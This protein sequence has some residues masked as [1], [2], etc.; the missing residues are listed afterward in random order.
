MRSRPLLLWALAGVL[1][2]AMP[3]PAATGP[4]V[5]VTT[6][7]TSG[8]VST[9]VSEGQAAAETPTSGTGAISGVVTDGVTGL[10]LE[11]AVVQLSGGGGVAVVPVSGG[12]VAAPRPGQI[13]DARGRF[14]FTHLPA[15][16]DYALS[17]SRAGYMPGGYKRVPG[18]LSVTR[19]A[20]RD[21]EWV[22]NA[23]VKLW[24][25]AS[26][27]GT[28]RDEL[29]EPVVGVPVRALVTVQV[30]G[31]GQRAAGPTTETDDRG[32]YRLAGLQPGTY[33]IQA[34]SV[35][36]T[37]PAVAAPARPGP[38]SA[39]PPSGRG[40]ATAALPDVPALVRVD[41]SLGRMVGHFATPPPDSGGKVYAM[42]FHPSARSV[43]EATPVS[44]GYGDQR[45]NVDVQLTLVPAVSVSGRVAGP[46]QSLAKMPIRLVPV[47]S[48]SLSVGADAAFTQ[49]DEEGSFT[50]LQVP[51]G[52]YTLIASRTMAEYGVGASS[53][54]DRVM[55]TSVLLITSMSAGQV[56]GSTGVSYVVRSTAGDAVSGRLSVSVGAADLEGLVVPL[57]T[58]V[59]VS[60]HFLWDGSETPPES[61]RLQPPVRLEPADGDLSLG[62]RN[63]MNVR[64]DGQALPSPLPFEL[65]GVL[66]GRY[67]LSY[68]ESGGF[69]LEGAEWNGRDLLAMPLEVDG[70]KDV[71]GV[72]IR[73]SSKRIALTGSVQDANGAPATTGAVLTFPASPALW[74]N[75]GLSANLFRTSTIVSDGTF[76]VDR[77][78]PGEYLIVAV[79]DEDRSKWLD[80]EFLAGVAG[81][82]TR[83]RVEPGATISRNLRMVGGRE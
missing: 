12:G 31:R 13:T 83:I 56:P 33:V 25:P 58:G 34:P 78:V 68:V 72:V 30:A 26:I 81:F 22:T 43:A 10:P 49:T 82:A 5:V 74:R 53:S 64:P 77:L 24:R 66:P 45:E 21:G 48:E 75:F 36:I 15:F 63:R 73:L 46:A 59:K 80:A 11:G 16:P 29:G 6:S 20:L 54:S 37:L 4:Q 41:G 39:A 3:A 57:M 14:I 44:V 79:P 35:Q 7:T 27:S 9:T 19:I 51:A 71:T 52:D 42:A 28:V 61:L 55:P 50:F 70:S 76:R 67:L 32:V 17:A 69:S 47:G 18:V 40:S 1:S 8:G 65:N 62:V 60:G 2:L 38:P 23:D